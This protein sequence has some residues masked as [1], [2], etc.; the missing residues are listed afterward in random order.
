MTTDPARWRLPPQLL[1][2]MQM[3]YRSQQHSSPRVAAEQL[4]CFLQPSLYRAVCFSLRRPECA[5][6]GCAVTLF[7]CADHRDPGSLHV[8]FVADV[9]T[10]SNRQE[11]DACG[12]HV[13]TRAWRQAPGPS[14]TSVDLDSA[15]P[16]PRVPTA[17]GTVVMVPP[18]LCVCQS[19][20]CLGVPLARDSLS[21]W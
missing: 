12:R 13:H 21:R 19:L 6:L 7:A 15:S 10:G 14:R 1:V 18:G 20:K 8:H 16:A 17:R 11:S 2:Q 5:C 4:T 9:L 3:L